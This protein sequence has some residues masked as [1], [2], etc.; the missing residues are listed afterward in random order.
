MFKI[1]ASIYSFFALFYIMS[2]Q[3]YSSSE[4]EA[5]LSFLIIAAV[6]II[7]I[8]PSFGAKSRRKE[9]ENINEREWKEG[10][11]HNDFT[12]VGSAEDYT[13]I[14]PIDM[15]GNAIEHARE[16]LNEDLARLNRYRVIDID[17]PKTKD[18]LNSVKK[19]EKEEE[20]EE[21]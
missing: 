14:K 5:L 2:Y 16:Q 1:I 4:R 11:Y 17:I 15:A 10:E 8:S 20:D 6:L 21:K 18:E 13:P 9:M 12:R 3:F 7:L 19:N